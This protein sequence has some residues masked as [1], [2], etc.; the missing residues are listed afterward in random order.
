MNMRITHSYLTETDTFYVRDM[1]N[2]GFHPPESVEIQQIDTYIVKSLAHFVEVHPL[3][4][5]HVHVIHRQGS[6][7]VAIVVTNGP[8]VVIRLT[9]TA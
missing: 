7:K 1:L 2:T 5:A 8:S 9:Q 3:E 4:S 6:S